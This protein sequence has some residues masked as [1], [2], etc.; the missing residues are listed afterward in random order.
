MQRSFLLAANVVYWEKYENTEVVQMK[1]L[2]ALILT[3]C[4]MLICTAALA[5]TAFGRLNQNVLT[6]AGPGTG[7]FDTGITLKRGSYVTVL[8]KTWD[9]PNDMYWLQIEFSVQGDRYRAYISDKCFMGDLSGVPEE[10]AL[11]V[12]YVTSDADVFA[13]PGWEYVMWNDTVYRGASGV[14][15]EAEDGYAHVEFWNDRWEQPWRVWISMNDLDC[16]DVYIPDTYSGASTSTSGKYNST[17]AISPVG[18]TA[19]IGASSG[20]AR[21]GAGTEYPIVE[22][23][24][25]GE[26]FT[27][28]DSEVATNG[29]TWYQIKKDGVLCWISSGICTVD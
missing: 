13:G 1:K 4:L 12:V 20:N 14:L 27:I 17:V 15:L 23:V 18:H 6:Y 21:S 26:R 24:F 7:F 25:C 9:Y 8:T 16:S 29:K 5:D 2:T 11:G 19:R 22:Y 3:L 28:L 10:E